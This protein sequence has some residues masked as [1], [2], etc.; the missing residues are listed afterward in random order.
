MAYTEESKIQWRQLS[1]ELQKMIRNMKPS[2][3]TSSAGDVK[4][5]ID[6]EDN[7]N[8]THTNTMAI[9][10]VDYLTQQIAQAEIDIALTN[11]AIAAAT[12]WANEFK[13]EID[14]ATTKLNKVLEGFINVSDNLT[15]IIKDDDT[16][17]ATIKVDTENMNFYI[18]THFHCCF[19]V[20]NDEELRVTKKNFEKE[21]NAA[22]FIGMERLKTYP[23]YAFIFSIHNNQLYIYNMKTKKWKDTLPLDQYL[24][25]N[26]ILYNTKYNRMYFYRGKDAYFQIGRTHVNPDGTIKSTPQLGV[27]KKYRNDGLVTRDSLL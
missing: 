27:T 23:D 5:F 19:V 24:S 1:P 2:S 6:T 16:R 13:S 14:T 12:Q 18:D 4:T 7:S 10:V 3:S 22:Y 20:S 11:P 15:S 17:M 25:P 9:N 26:I 21:N 8:N